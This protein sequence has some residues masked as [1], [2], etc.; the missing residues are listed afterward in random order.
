M[1][2]KEKTQQLPADFVFAMTE[3]AYYTLCAWLEGIGAPA[4]AVDL[5]SGLHCLGTPAVADAD[6]VAQTV[7][8][9]DALGGAFN[10]PA[11]SSISHVK[12]HAQAWAAAR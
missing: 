12:E 2:T 7:R 9:I 1:S 4:A 6:A 3:N 11:T 5:L 10:G 8:A